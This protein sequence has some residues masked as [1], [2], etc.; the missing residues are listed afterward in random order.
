VVTEAVGD[1][2]AAVITVN[3]PNI[4]ALLG[5]E[6]GVFPPGKHDRDA[7]LRV[8]E[9]FIDGHRRAVESVRRVAPGVPVGMALAMA[10]WQS[11]PGGER[12]LD[13][14]RQLREDVFAAATGSDDFIGVNTYTRHR[15]GPQ[16]WVGNEPGV[17]LTGAGY[18]FWP[19]ALEA[20]VKRAYALCGGLPVIVTESGIATDDDDRRIA[21]ID[22]AVAAMRRAMRAGCDVRGFIYW[23]ALDNFEWH[24]GYSQRF[25]LMSVERHTQQRTVNPSAWHLGAIAQAS[26]EG[27]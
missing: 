10:D 3:E 18:E 8:T 16:G 2:A 4:P 5:Y 15:I 19:Q 14:V 25:G 26:P 27:L 21:F 9:T 1:L 13:E 7:R 22:A 11:V 23:S 20:T 6:K 12:E 17:E 24:C